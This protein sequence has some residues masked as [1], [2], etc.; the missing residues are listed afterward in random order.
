VNQS[1]LLGTALLSHRLTVGKGDERP[2]ITTWSWRKWF[3]C[4]K[5]TACFM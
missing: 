5:R 4:Q 3:I 2:L 1:F